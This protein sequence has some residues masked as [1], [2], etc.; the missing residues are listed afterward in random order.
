MKLQ[1]YVRRV[2]DFANRQIIAAS[3]EPLGSF[4]DHDLT[5]RPRE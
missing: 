1:A 4:G 3:T 5:N 2:G